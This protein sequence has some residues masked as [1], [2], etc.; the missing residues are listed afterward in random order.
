M[1]KQTVTGAA[2]VVSTGHVGLV[3]HIETVQQDVAAIA[4]VDLDDQFAIA[5]ACGHVGVVREL[6]ALAGDRRVDVH[7]MDEYALRLACQHGHVGVVRGL[8]VLAGDRRVDVN[9]IEGYAL[10]HACAKG[11]LHVA[12]ELFVLSVDRL[13][14]LT[15]DTLPEAG[16]DMLASGLGDP[17]SPTV[18]AAWRA[19]SSP[20]GMMMHPDAGYHTRESAR[21]GYRVYKWCV[22]GVVVLRRQ[23]GRGQ[24]RERKRPV[25]GHGSA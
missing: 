9:S 19:I 23:E 14:C 3:H 4:T 8:L 17:N 5:C 6:L 21:A 18:A 2:P 11:R 25:S 10:R 12:C 1:C 7:S 15:P 13:A 16:R 22:R 20:D 24:G